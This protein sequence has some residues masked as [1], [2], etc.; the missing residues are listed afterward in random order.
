MSSLLFET[1]Y[2]ESLYISHCENC[3]PLILEALKES[4]SMPTQIAPGCNT[5][6]EKHHADKYMKARNLT[7]K[8]GNVVL[9]GK[10]VHCW[11]F[12]NDSRRKLI[13]IIKDMMRQYS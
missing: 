13:T 6:G 3:R 5:Y 7:N 9:D 2:S 10:Y 4:V 1:P 11:K 12:T 8:H